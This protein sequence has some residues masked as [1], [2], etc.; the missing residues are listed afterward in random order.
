MKRKSDFLKTVVQHYDLKR[1]NVVPMVEAMGRTAFSAR[2]LSSAA[3]LYDQ[4]LR[5]PKCSIFLCLAGSLVS[6]GLKK[7]V[8]D[9]LDHDMVDVVV[10]TGANMVD[11]DFFE[12]LGFRHYQGSP[13][14]DDDLLRQLGI[15]RIYDTLI[16]EEELA[17]VDRVI[18]RIAADLPPRP[19]SSREFILEMT[20]Y[21]KK[22]SKAQDSILLSAGRRGVPIFVPAFNDCAAGFGLMNHQIGFPD[23]HVT[24]DSIKDFRELAAVKAAA[25]QSGLLMVGGGVPKN[26]VQ[27]VALATPGLGK[28]PVMHK[29]ALQITVAD[30]RD[31]A[32]SSSTLK[33]ACSWGKVSIVNEQMVF[34]EATLALPLIAG[35]A[36]HKG[37]W[38]N[39]K[40]RNYTRL[41]DGD[42]AAPVEA[43]TNGNRRPAVAK[44]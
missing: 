30:V 5:D 31:G 36:Y 20:R 33:E 41:L 24:I 14:V 19:Y 11:Q 34:A 9:L 2:D 44:V 18:T 4:M 40:A 38:K 39:R 8:C 35:Y 26:F 43:R 22:N 1:T 25:D 7:I 42:A 29:Y 13:D 16:D 37:S 32:L 27:D 28:A 23:A 6:A 3:A 15:S 10:S 17:E 21:L 12:A